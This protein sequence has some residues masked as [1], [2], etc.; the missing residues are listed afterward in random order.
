MEMDI[1]E[2]IEFMKK[3]AEKGQEEKAWSMWIARYIL[4]DKESFVPFEEFCDMLLGKNLSTKP[5]EEILA[6]AFEIERKI[7]LKG[8]EAYG[9]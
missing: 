4:M 2:G 1:D 9:S 8:G 5:R 6:E 7:K 3:A